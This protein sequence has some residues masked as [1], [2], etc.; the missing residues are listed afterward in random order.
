M[1]FKWSSV[2]EKRQGLTLTY[3]IRG[4]FLGAEKWQNLKDWREIWF[5]TCDK[6]A[7]KNNLS[8]DFW[9]ILFCRTNCTKN[10]FLFIIQNSRNL[11]QIQNFSGSQKYFYFHD[12]KVRQI[13]KIVFKSFLPNPNHFH[14]YDTSANDNAVSTIS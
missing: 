3:R 7:V 14:F 9:K 8:D 12:K 6:N 2:N 1:T 5:W 13:W 10:I 4:T 11:R